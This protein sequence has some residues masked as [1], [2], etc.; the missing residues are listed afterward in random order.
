LSS[1]QKLKEKQRT[2]GQYIQDHRGDMNAV[3]GSP[4][5]SQMD[6]FKSGAKKYK[7][8]VNQMEDVLAKTEAELQDVGLALP[9]A[10]HSSVPIGAEEMAVELERFGPN[11]ISTDGDRDHLNIAQHWDLVDNDASSIAS[12]SSW[13][14]LKGALALLEQ[15]LI[16]YAISIAVKH[17][18]TPI[19]PPDVIRSDIAWRCGFQP[20]DSTGAAASQ[21][22]SIIVPEGSPELC[23]AGTAEV[24]LSA[25]FANKIIPQAELPLR[26]VGIGRAF[27]AEAGARGA[28]TRGL[29]RVHQF[30]KVE[31]FSVTEENKSESMMEELRDIQ[32]EIA[33]SLGLSV[34]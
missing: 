31:L 30:Q 9:N 15:A 7:E 28:D 13:P 19:S 2:I 33:E 5:K 34:R 6:E 3:R 1:L 20:R 16:Q 27:R 8:L 21:T 14:Y 18:Y 24:P 25:L 17:G 11:P 29:Y 23:L 10:T 4:A 22:Y 26:V 12:G 32:K